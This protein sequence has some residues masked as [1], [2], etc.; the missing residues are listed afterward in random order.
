M[1][2]SKL[3]KKKK[4][5]KGFSLKS[6]Q[7]VADNIQNV[8]ELGDLPKQ[9]LYRLSQI[10]SKRRVLTPRTLN[11]FLRPDLSS[12]DIYDCASM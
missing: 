6:R 4:K 5:K 9:L 11:L 7:T 1:H 8:D 3:I 2:Q 10:L 12:I